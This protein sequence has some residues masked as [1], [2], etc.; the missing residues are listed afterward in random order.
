MNRT[1][2]SPRSRGLS[3]SALE[4]VH[5]VLLVRVH[6]EVIRQPALPATTTCRHVVPLTIVGADD[7]L[8]TS[9]MSGLHIGLL[10]K[11]AM[12]ANTSFTGCSRRRCAGTRPPQFLPAIGRSLATGP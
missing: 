10:L 5:A 6:G 2:R 1:C 7:V 9:A 11:S 8:D 12:Y 4:A 3:R